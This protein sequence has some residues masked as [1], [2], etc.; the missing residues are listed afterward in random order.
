MKVYLFIA[1]LN[2]IL[3]NTIAM[4]KQKT[5]TDVSKDEKVE[6]SAQELRA[7]YSLM[8]KSQASP[9]ASF[10]QKPQEAKDF[11]LG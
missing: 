11:C 9:T 5:A 3:S 10:D 7:L 6:P 4:D 2:F 1:S 8:Q